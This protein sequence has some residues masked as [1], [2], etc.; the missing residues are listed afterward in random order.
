MCFAPISQQATEQESQEILA[1]ATDDLD[2]LRARNSALVDELD[3]SRKQLEVGPAYIDY[4]AGFAFQYEL[5]C[6][7]ITS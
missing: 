7:S 2:A 4:I 5:T 3:S 1:R 6:I